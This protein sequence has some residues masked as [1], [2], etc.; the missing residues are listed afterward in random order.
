MRHYLIAALMAGATA[1]PAFA[2]DT[3]PSPLSSAGFHI[4]VL[5]GYDSSRIYTDD[6][7][8][9]VY[10]IGAGYDLMA[11]RVLLGI[12]AEASDSTNRGCDSGLVTPADQICARASRDFYVGGRAGTHV[13]RNVLLYAKAG[14]TNARFR[15]DYDD[16]TPAGTSNFSINDNL[17]GIRV[18]LGAEFAVGRNAFIRT[19][20]RYSN[21]EG[22]SDR[23]QV[24]GGFGLRF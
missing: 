2:Q 9:V 19:E 13:A 12:E 15:I 14:Y 3:T 8:G 24:I 4:E 20:G 5:G 21:Y 1:T 17:D 22:G 23:G 18:G 6:D 16:G 7:G 11:G 10:G